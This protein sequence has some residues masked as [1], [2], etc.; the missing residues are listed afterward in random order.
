MKKRN[1]EE[2]EAEDKV[3]AVKRQIW[4]SADRDCRPIVMQKYWVYIQY[5]SIEL[6]T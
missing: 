1:S 3:L 4:S 2:L 5:S 6:I